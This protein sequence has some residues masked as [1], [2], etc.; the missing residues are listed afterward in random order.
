MKETTS[1]EKILKKIRKGLIH[2]TLQPFPEIESGGEIYKQSSESPDIQ[3][4]EEFAKVQG[5]FVYCQDQHEM[6]EN[7]QALSEKKGWN[8]LYC[9][10]KNLLGLFQEKNF[11]VRSD[12]NIEKADAGITTCEV[13]IAR[14][15]SIL[16]SS[17]QAS[18]RTLSIFPPVHI[19]VGYTSQLVRNISDGMKMLQEKYGERMPS[20]INL[21]TG[22]S[23]TADIEKT[24]VLGAHGP[25]EV[26][27]FLIDEATV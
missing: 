6:V 1:K 16:L 13:L 3:F 9:W 8:N 26:Y 23:R 22:P 2:Q 15:G 17:K 21:S 27:L 24:L 19:M 20:M 18:G 12:K 11:A 5:N 4:A 14:T 7:L 10:D 25:K